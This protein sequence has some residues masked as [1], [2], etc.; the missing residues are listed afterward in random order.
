MDATHVHEWAVVATFEARATQIIECT[1]C[2]A[3]EARWLRP[4]AAAYDVPTDPASLID[5]DCCQ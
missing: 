3:Q 5:T 1:R 2:H 4:V